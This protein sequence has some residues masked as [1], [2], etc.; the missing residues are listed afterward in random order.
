MSFPEIP[1]GTESLKST[2]RACL[3]LC[4]GLITLSDL[5]V[6][7]TVKLTFC[8]LLNHCASVQV[9]IADGLPQT[10]CPECQQSALTSYIFRLKCE[11]SQEIL[12]NSVPSLVNLNQ[13]EGNIKNECL[14]SEIDI[15][16]EEIQ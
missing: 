7:N 13:T 1:L 15:K 12:R 14:T 11:K 4:D 2:C 8:A 5:V 3:S 6:I 10:I 16:P 9:T